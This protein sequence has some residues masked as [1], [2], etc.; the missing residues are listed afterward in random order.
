MTSNPCKPPLPARMF[1]DWPRIPV[2]TSRGNT[3]RRINDIAERAASAWV[4]GPDGPYKQPGMTMHEIVSGAVHEGLLHLAELGLIDIDTARL[5]TA[6]G[7]PIR[8]TDCRPDPVPGRAQVIDPDGRPVPAPHLG[9]GANA[10]DCPAC[11]DTT[12]PYPFIC[13]GPTEDS[14]HG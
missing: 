10:A 2:D 9:G 5:A 6:P 4:T 7:I 3:F 14:T 13:P 8:R 11:H 12:P 1:D